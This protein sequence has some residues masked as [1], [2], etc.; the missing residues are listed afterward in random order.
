M[1]K[2]KTEFELGDFDNGKFRLKIFRPE[3]Y[4]DFPTPTLKITY[5]GKNILQRNRIMYGKT[6][7]TFAVNILKALKSKKLKQ[8]I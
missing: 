5:E 8:G 1:S 7:E 4:S 6:L 2:M 3:E